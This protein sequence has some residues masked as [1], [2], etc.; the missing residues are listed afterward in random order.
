MRFRS[1]P[2]TMIMTYY[3]LEF[4]RNFAQFRRFGRQQRQ[5]E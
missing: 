1:T 5:N 4:S 3:K 2:R